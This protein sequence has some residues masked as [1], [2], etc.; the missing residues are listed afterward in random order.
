MAF[1]GLTKLLTKL[2][3][4]N[5]FM[6]EAAVGDETAVNMLVKD[7]YGGRYGLELPGDFTAS[8]S[9]KLVVLHFQ[10]TKKMIRKKM[11]TLQQRPF[12]ANAIFAAQFVMIA[13]HC[14]NFTFE[15]R[16]LWMPTRYFHWKL[17]AN[18]SYSNPYPSIRN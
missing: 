17:F 3:S 6:E 13:K 18:E 2:K 10:T 11:A 4:F 1:F 8:F 15:R 9:A 12:P 7:I 5:E 14:T 16:H